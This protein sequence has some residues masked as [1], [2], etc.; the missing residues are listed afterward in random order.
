MPIIVKNSPILILLLAALSLFVCDRSRV[1]EE[2]RAVGARG[3]H[4]DSAQTFVLEYDEG[5]QRYDAY[6][7]LRV[8]SDYPYQNLYVFVDQRYGNG[9]ERRDTVNYRLAAPSGELL[10]K[11]MG[12]LK[13]FMLPVF[14]GGTLPEAGE[15]SITLT[16]GMRDTQLVGLEDVGFRLALH[17]SD[18]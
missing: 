17:E 9:E 12:A 8:N 14:T 18:S 11:G 13:E 16:H 4:L 7:A 1:Y 2:Y 5:E 15:Y 3:W 10:G 6:M